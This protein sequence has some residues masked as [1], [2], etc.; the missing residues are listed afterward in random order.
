MAKNKEKIM[1]G[2]CFNC[3]KKRK[4]KVVGED[5]WKGVKI[6]I[7]LCQWCRAAAT[8]RAMQNLTE[9]EKES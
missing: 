7:V 5:S 1:F 3:Q 9:G 6:P 2:Y 8:K 4:V